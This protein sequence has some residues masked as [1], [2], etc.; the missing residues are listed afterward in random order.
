M[1]INTSVSVLIKILA[2]VVAAALYATSAAAGEFYEKD[3]AAIRGYDPVAYF[4]EGKPVKG[5]PDYKAE[6]QGLDV[7]L[8]I[9]GESRCVRGRPGEVCPAVRRLLRV[10]NGRR[11]QGRDAAVGVHDRRQQALSELQP[12]RA[13][14]VE[15]RH[16]GLCQDVRMESGP[17]CRDRARSSNEVARVRS[18]LGLGL[19]DL[20]FDRLTLRPGELGGQRV[21]EHA[22][23]RRHQPS[24]GEHRPRA[25][26]RQT[27]IRQHLDELAALQVRQREVIVH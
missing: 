21:E 25:D 6:L 5:S 1:R 26:R 16:P 17:R 20:G 22:R 18:Q 8:Q 9:A 3:G 23:S 7:L 15:Q 24:A 27:P 4:T 10:R 19:L 12:G 14:E 2:L 13:E 11:L